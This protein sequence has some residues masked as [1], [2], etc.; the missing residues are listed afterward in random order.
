MTAA[1][2]VVLRRRR[3]SGSGGGGGGSAWPASA[4]L[5]YSVAR[6]MNPDYSGNLIRVRRSSDNAE[7][8]IGAASGVLDETALLAHCGAGD[9]FVVKVYEQS[10]H[11]SAVD[12]GQATAGLQPKIVN[13]GAVVKVDGYP[14]FNVS[15]ATIHMAAETWATRPNDATSVSVWAEGAARGL[16]SIEFSTPDGGGNPQVGIIQDGSATTTLSG[17]SGTLSYYKNGGLVGTDSDGT[18]RGDMHT[19]FATGALLVSRTAGINFTLSAQYDELA[20]TF[21]AA[22]VWAGREYYAETLIMNAPTAEEISAWEAEVASHYG[23]IT[24]A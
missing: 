12:W 5:A 6:V 23:G 10:G 20:T 2:F 15:S 9:G 18:T 19:A 22:G 17:S 3:I 1:P 11:A 14:A 24:L 7:A 13:S 8:D 4:V 16:I 21:R